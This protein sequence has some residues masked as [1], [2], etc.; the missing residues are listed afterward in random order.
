MSCPHSDH[1]KVVS[2]LR[3]LR[4]MV[5]VYLAEGKLAETD[6]L[7]E[8]LQRIEFLV[9]PPL[10]MVLEMIEQI[11]KDRHPHAAGEGGGC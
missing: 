9:G 4:S 11:K 8:E 6:G 5:L 7:M 1:E 10:P 3:S 2:A